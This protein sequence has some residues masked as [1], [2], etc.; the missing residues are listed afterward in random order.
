MKN[1]YKEGDIKIS[2]PPT[3]LISAIGKI[4]DIAKAVSMDIKAPGDYLYLIGATAKE[5]GG[6]EYALMKKL[7]GGRVPKRQCLSSHDSL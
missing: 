1:D 6:S 7:S 3:L 5:L 2:I 4:P